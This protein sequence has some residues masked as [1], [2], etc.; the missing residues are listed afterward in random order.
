[1]LVAHILMR[2][3]FF[4]CYL[5]KGAILAIALLWPVGL[6]AFAASEE[7]SE[8]DSS[9]SRLTMVS[10]PKIALG[11][12]NAVV[13]KAQPASL[14]EN[15]T[16]TVMPSV[17]PESM[18]LA[19]KNRTVKRALSTLESAKPVTSGMKSP[20]VENVKP[21]NQTEKRQANQEAI[22]DP[23]LVTLNLGSG[24]TQDLEILQWADGSYSLPVKAFADVLG[25]TV[26]QPP[27]ETRLLFVD[28][29][30]GK[31]VELDWKAQR[32]LVDD[33][34]V[35]L[36]THPIVLSE[37][38][39]VNKGD[40]YL[41][42]SILGPILQSSFSYDEDNTTLSISTPRK[43]KIVGSKQ[44]DGSTVQTADIKLI[45]QPNLYRALVEKVYVRNASN[46]F[47]QIPRSSLGAGPF[48]NNTMNS[49]M[50]SSTVGASGSIFGQNYYFKPTF[51]RFNGK[52]N[53]QSIDWSIQHGFQNSVLS[54]GSSDAGLSPLSS[55]S[56]N[57]WG[58]KFASKNAITPYLVSRTNYEFSGAATEGHEV[59]ARINGRTV[60]TTVAQAN[61]YE[62]ESVYLQPQAV[63]H[64]QIVELD[65]QKQEKVLVDKTIS[66]Y[67]NLL[68]KGESAYSGFMGRAPLLFFPPQSN[69]NTPWLMPQSN[70]WLAGGRM[71]YGL[72]DRLT[73]GVSAVADRVFGQ[74]RTYYTSLDPFS[75][76]LTGINSYLRDSN[77]FQGENMSVTLRY[78]MTEH[79]LLTMDT[80]V[81]RFTL[82]P[83]SHLPIG[84]SNFDIANQLHLEHQGSR[85][86]WF[87]DAFRYGSN[88]YTPSVM[89]YGNNLYDKRGMTM[90]VNG[91]LSRYLR[92]NYSV[93]WSKYQTNFKD[94][95]AGGIINANQWN[96][97][98]SSHVN[99]HND[100]LL[101]LN[102]IQGQNDLRNFDQH[103]V[104]LT[105]RTQSLPWRLMGEVRASHYYTNTIFYPTASQGIELNQSN[106]TNNAL[107]LSL[108]IPLNL[109]K[110]S[111]LKIGNRLSTFVDYGFAQSSFKIK[112]FSFEPLIQLSYGNRPQIQNRFGLKLGYQLGSGAIFSVGFYKN[113]STFATTNTL[114]GAF[115]S[116]IDSNQ[117]YCDFSDIL[118]LFG[119]KLRSLGPN[120]DSSGMVVGKIFAD[121]QA[122]GKPD[123]AEPGVHQVNL[124][125][126]K[127]ITVKTDNKG[128]YTVP[129]LS[130][131][132]HTLEI[133]PDS[134]PLTLGADNPIFKI[135]VNSG[136]TQRLD[137][138]LSPEGGSLSGHIVFTNIKGDALPMDSIV[139]VLSDGHGKVLNYTTPDSDGNYQFGNVSAGQYQVDLEPKLKSS[140]RYRVLQSPPL[141]AI[142]IPKSYDQPVVLEHQD[143]KLLAL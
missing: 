68:P 116:K 100:I 44:G 99:D 76:D 86:T 58:L 121:Y 137:I 128:Q 55:P 129:G 88:Y 36:T 21:Q 90:G 91:T 42:Q 141:A 111:Y 31:K 62:L 9:S 101:G 34:V 2:R 117:F 105:W 67:Y 115:H 130:A 94:L 30:S 126:D 109:S 104:D 41:D 22:P 135:K 66:N 132:Y 83:G 131:G 56:L 46:Y 12:S 25:I 102:W 27:N 17:Q 16:T 80:G 125:V 133:L 92:L 7:L 77:F 97:S 123:K 53:F 84:N 54:L 113:F 107:D 74:P 108:N 10:N 38:G 19:A 134:L 142:N 82:L 5:L 1:M 79:W 48:R 13:Q 60:Q 28:S 20:A 3:A 89:L 64:L 136:K 138:P 52:I 6:D 118:S 106:Y 127:Q 29:V 33:Q 72:S 40:V 98:L 103:S 14:S 120:S 43:L 50:D 45:A 23:S 26:Q 32:L 87:M 18:A 69:Q 37:R 63:N 15:N 57:V 4:P 93:K 112:R 78:Q 8:R 140:G 47:Q 24:I 75:I 71:F 70:K 95:I 122:N 35:A 61:G 85:M 81:S 73:A 39:L 143:L 51:T 119:Q 124:L 139:L 49:M 11:L 114:G 65:G 96:A 110:T 59:Q